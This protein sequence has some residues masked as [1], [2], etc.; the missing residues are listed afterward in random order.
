MIRGQG[1]RLKSIEWA[2]VDA[3]SMLGAPKV[4]DHIGKEKVLEVVLSGRKKVEERLTFLRSPKTLEELSEKE[5]RRLQEGPGEQ[6]LAHL[7]EET[8]EASAEKMLEQYHCR[9]CPGGEASRA[10]CSGRPPC[11]FNAGI[12]LLGDRVPAEVC[13]LGLSSMEPDEMMIMAELL[14][15]HVFEDELE[16]DEG[17]MNQSQ[18]IAAAGAWLRFFA[19]KGISMKV[20]M[21]ADCL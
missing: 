18:V 5:V 9:E 2:P 10:K 13:G 4:K 20:K 19:E 8:P 1:M 17:E 7:L 16:I 15:G 21:C 11:W 14:G 12:T 3:C 6:E